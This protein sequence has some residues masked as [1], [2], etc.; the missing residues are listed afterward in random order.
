MLSGKLLKGRRKISGEPLP[1]SSELVEAMF[2]IIPK[3]PGNSVITVKD[4]L[5][6]ESQFLRF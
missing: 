4:H 1:F 3:N 2:K 6:F 5:P